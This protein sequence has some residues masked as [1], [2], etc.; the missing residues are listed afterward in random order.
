MKPVVLAFSGPIASGKTTIAHAIAET[1]NWRFASFGDFVRKEAHRR[2]L[3]SSR[4]VLQ[5]LGNEIISQGWESF[6][7]AVL[8]DSGW[9]CGQGLI[10][11]GIRH[12]E[13]LET[14]RKLVSPVPTFLAFVQIDDQTRRARL[15]E[16]NILKGRELKR[17]DTHD[18]ERQVKGILEGVADVIVDGALPV[19]ITVRDLIIWLAIQSRE[20]T[21][22]KEKASTQY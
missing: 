17:I 20:E 16:K 9:I 13:G 11:D 5:D 22:K 10:I 15:H 18:T 2:Q 19:E 7:Q 4:K 1:L 14:V 3:E 6:C 12:I 8:V 21:E